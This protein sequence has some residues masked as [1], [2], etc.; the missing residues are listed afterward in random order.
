MFCNKFSLP[1][2]VLVL[3]L[4][5]FGCSGALKHQS[6]IDKK[7]GMSYEEFY[8]NSHPDFEEEKKKQEAKSSKS[9]LEEVEPNLIPS[10]PNVSQILSLPQAPI[11]DKDRL[12]SLSVTEDIPL[13]DVLIELG[14]LADIEL[15]IDPKI[16]GGIILRVKDKPLGQVIERIS[17]LAQ[18]R[19]S[20]QEGILSIENDSPFIKTYPLD[21]LNNTRSIETK[22]NINTALVKNS[23]SSGSTGT[24]NTISNSYNGDLWKSIE[25]DLKQILSLTYNKVIPLAENIHSEEKGATGKSAASDIIDQYISINK[26]AS[27]LSVYATE[28]QHKKIQYY[29]NQVKQSVSA[30]VLIEAKVV[31]VQL[32]DEFRAGIDWYKFANPFG[33]SIGLAQS[34]N[35]PSTNSLVSDPTTTPFQIGLFPK[36]VTP[37]GSIDANGVFSF[38]PTN[39]D[40]LVKLTEYFGTTRTISSP[41]ITAMNNQQAILS[42]ITNQVYFTLKVDNNNTVSSS[43]TASNFATI[44]STPNTVPIGVILTIQPSINTITNEVTMSVKPTIS[45]ITGNVSDPSIAFAIANNQISSSSS[46]ST[47]DVQSL[48]P[49]VEVKELD[50]LL[51]IKSGEVMVIGGLMQETANNIES[52]LPGVKNIPFLGNLF[53]SVDKATTIT[54]TVI[55]LKATIVPSNYTPK[56]D[57]RFYNNFGRKF[58]HT[59]LF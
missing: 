54:Q 15:E 3:F 18:L 26:Q 40:A 35:I 9:T 11:K 50:S 5:V 22:T 38:S 29:L 51:K 12:V 39:L 16:E 10:L 56:E 48:I 13:K 2:A 6:I 21:F 34:Y 36:K 31:E 24:S 46:S 58:D 49:I 27:L 8:K 17:R 19:Y 23:S 53:K 44:D 43:G 7:L 30:Q 4:G 41:R 20:Y 32:N 55:F 25:N 42:F 28:A 33:N 59:P 1:L 47:T 37:S 57:K 52:G 45:A 14:R